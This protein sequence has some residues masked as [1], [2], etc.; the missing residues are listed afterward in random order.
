MVNQSGSLF[1]EPSR[2]GC[3][4]GLVVL[5]SRYARYE[6]FYITDLLDRADSRLNFRFCG[7]QKGEETNP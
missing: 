7:Q 4:Y 1:A 6:V 3:I 5:N 2:G